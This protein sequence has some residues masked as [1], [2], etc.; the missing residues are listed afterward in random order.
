MYTL[1]Y[2]VTDALNTT[3]EINGKWLPAR[4]LAGPFWARLKDAWRVLTGKAD[5]FTWPE[6]Q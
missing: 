3:K 6:G 5:A 2:L 4:P 1:K